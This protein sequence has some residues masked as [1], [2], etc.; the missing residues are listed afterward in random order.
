M[1]L[2]VQ[3][4]DGEPP[5]RSG[6]PRLVIRSSIT[7]A[8]MAARRTHSSTST[9]NSM[10]EVVSSDGTVVMSSEWPIGWLLDGTGG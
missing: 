10:V 1:A 8:I 5:C 3:S 7:Q 4:V 2:R 9:P 6:R